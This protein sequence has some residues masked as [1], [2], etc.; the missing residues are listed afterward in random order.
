MGRPA[1][2]ARGCG[3]KG[4]PRRLAAP[5]PPAADTPRSMADWA[6]LSADRHGDHRGSSEEEVGGLR[7]EADRPPEP[8]EHPG[9]ERDCS[10]GKV[11]HSAQT[12]QNSPA[13]RAVPLRLA[14]VP[15]QK[16]AVPPP[17]AEVPRAEPKV[18]LLM[19]KVP[20]PKA[21]VLPPKTG[22]PPSKTEVPP[23]KT[24]VPPPKA[25]VPP[26][27]T[28]VLGTLPIRGGTLGRSA[29]SSRCPADTEGTRSDGSRSRV[30]EGRFRFRRYRSQPRHPTGGA[31]ES[32]AV[33]GHRMDLLAWSVR[34]AART[35]F[36]SSA[37][38]GAERWMEK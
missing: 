26:P 22:V 29:S 33:S 9:E 2:V 24:E 35:R 15:H 38:K 21:E 10:G 6:G 31:A 20:L 7:E 34:H 12:G 16:L 1:A 11:D 3:V 17:K 37:G 23:P 8:A 4:R 25:E 19:T 18:P 27:K 30:G 14:A 28:E 36:D 5:R 13:K 32:S